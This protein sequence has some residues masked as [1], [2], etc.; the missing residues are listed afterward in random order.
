[1]FTDANSRKVGDVYW[2]RS[3]AGKRSFHTFCL[4]DLDGRLSTTGGANNL[5]IVIYFNI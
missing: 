4:I 1:M 3:T 5:G 2:T